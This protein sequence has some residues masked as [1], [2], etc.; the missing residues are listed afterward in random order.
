MKKNARVLGVDMVKFSKPGTNEPY[1]VMAAKAVKGALTDAG[2]EYREV[3]QAFAGYVYGDSTCGQRALYDIGMTGIPIINVN[4]NCS[5]G[6]SAL[7][8]ARQ[9]VESGEVECALAFGFEEMKPG[10]WEVFGKIAHHHSAG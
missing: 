1:E 5:S 4:N 2:I 7:F 8:M 6:S 3:E 9:A 10:P